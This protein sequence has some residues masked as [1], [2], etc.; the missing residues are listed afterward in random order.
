MLNGWECLLKS[1]HTQLP[2]PLSSLFLLL[3]SPCQFG[4][5]VKWQS[6]EEISGPTAVPMIQ[7]LFIIP[8]YEHSMFDLITGLSKAQT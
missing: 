1:L 3:K 7:D 5:A 6:F 2:S 8:P 4:A